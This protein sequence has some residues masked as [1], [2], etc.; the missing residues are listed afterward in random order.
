MT[1]GETITKSR[2]HSVLTSRAQFNP[3]STSA[4]SSENSASLPAAYRSS[5]ALVREKYRHL[6][7]LAVEEQ[8]GGSRS[9]HEARLVRHRG[10]NVL[11]LRGDWIEMAFQHGRLLAD[12]IPQGAVPQSAKLVGDAIANVFWSRRKLEDRVF[13]GAQHFLTRRL[14]AT[15]SRRLTEVFGED[16]TL[17]ELI[18][19]CDGARL[20]IS[21]AIQ[22][23]YN[24][25]LLLILAKYQ[26][27]RAPSGGPQAAVIPPTCCSSFA[28]WG[29]MTAG[30]ELLVG[31][32][33]DYPLNG[34][35]DRFPTV[36][37]F[38]PPAPA[39]RYMSFVSAGVHNAGITAYNEAGIFLASHVVPSHEIGLHGV[40]AMVAADHIIRQATT[41]DEAAELFRRLPPLAGWNY[42]VASANEGKVAS[43]EMTSGHFGVRAAEGDWH[44]QT[45]HFLTPE[46]RELN[47]L[48][49]ASVDED[50]LGRAQ[51][52]RQRLTEALGRLDAAEAA[53]ILGDQVDPQVNEVRGLGNTI[54]CHTTLGSVVLD[55]A[56]GRVLVS[57]GPAPACH[58][59][60]V[61]LP[62][63]GT[64]ARGE[65]PALDERTACRDSFERDHPEKAAA[66][67]LF[68]EAKTAY[69]MRNDAARACELMKQ[70]VSNDASNP[71][72]FF[73]LGIFALKNGHYEEAIEALDGVFRT[74][75]VTAQLR[76]LAH[77]YLGRAL[78]HLRKP[79]EALVH[80]QAVLD[81]PS[82]DRK[83]RTAAHKAAQRTKLF[84]R[85]A[86]RKRSLNIMVQ[87]SDMLHY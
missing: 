74:P 28:A 3:V 22:G 36:I 27:R 78:G 45:N 34:Y 23:I 86:L 73:Q 71:A 44:V 4:A 51:R 81:D 38:E 69:E 42:L 5:A 52:M 46:L 61:A 83:L 9:F 2:T 53:S 25:E 7:E 39:L 82:T 63:A 48:L 47:L 8:P 58:S 68:I 65:F 33:L 30:G 6:Y 60:F 55:P 35:F 37:Y 56:R 62:L 40:P 24:P 80:L 18:A 26:G 77:Y 1:A 15:A 14:F 41:L 32:N 13:V 49:N 16:D 76:R 43:L 75:Y 17:T 66:Q 57:T 21:Q 67:R 79:S 59:E 19:L 31:R 12:Q 20:S 10:L 72:Y 29:S 84:G 50:S 11:R 70:V 85:C 87:H 54:G 64:F